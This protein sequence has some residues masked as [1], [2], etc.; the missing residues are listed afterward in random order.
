NRGMNCDMS[1][2][3]GAEIRVFFAFTLVET[4][5]DLFPNMDISYPGLNINDT[6]SAA[7]ETQFDSDMQKI[8]YK[9]FSY[10]K[11]NY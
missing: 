8:V 4:N 11:I 10:Q 6:F 1:L 3:K 7:I 2:H 5:P 9:V